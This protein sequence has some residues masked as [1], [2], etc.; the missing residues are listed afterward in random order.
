M[1]RELDE[2]QKIHLE[3]ESIELYQDQKSKL[4]YEWTADDEE[5]FL[6]NI[7]NLK[8]KFTQT[9]FL[10]HCHRFKFITDS[11]LKTLASEEISRKLDKSNK[12]FL[13]RQ[14]LL[15]KYFS[16]KETLTEK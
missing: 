2:D 3:D 12:A 5:M 1:G 7:K 8:E 14:F 9:Q 11:E 6:Q 16:T 10:K 4:N 15:D 13:S